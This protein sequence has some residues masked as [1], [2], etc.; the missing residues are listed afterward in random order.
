VRRP[1]SLLL[2]SRPI[3]TSLRIALRELR[4]PGIGIATLFATLVFAAT[5][6]VLTVSLTQSVRDGLR[7]SAQQTIGGDISLRLF[8]RAPRI[9][10]IAFLET[11]GTLSLTI[12]QRVMVQPSD[13]QT[14]V[15][16]E[17]KAVDAAYPLFGHLALSPDIP[18]S[19]ALG[20]SD[21]TPGIVVGPEL[22]EEGGYRVG[23]TLYLGGQPYQIRARI[24]AEPERK[25]RLF[26]LGPRVIVGLN[27]YRNSPLL[28]PGKQVYW[29]LRI[30]L[31]PNNTRSPSKA[32]FQI[33]DGGLSVPRTASPGSNASG[34]SHLPSSA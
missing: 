16:S 11:L 1:T 33:A 26:S 4:K 17:L 32:D 19:E 30:K 21:G 9:D 14:A 7:Q 12:E 8:H 24:A 34:I 22:V 15:L 13:N 28:A 3:P 23:D 2:T 5:I 10:E 6:L 25:F 29:Y 31:P 27:A 20:T 18:L